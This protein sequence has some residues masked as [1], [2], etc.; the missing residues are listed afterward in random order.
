MLELKQSVID[1]W[2]SRLTVAFA[3]RDIT[4]NTCLIKMLLFLANGHHF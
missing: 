3:P 4:F 2:Q 1:Q